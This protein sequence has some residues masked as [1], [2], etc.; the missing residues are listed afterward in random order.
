MIRLTYLISQISF[1]LHFNEKIIFLKLPE[2]ET[3]RYSTAKIEKVTYFM[4]SSFKSSTLYLTVVSRIGILAK[5]IIFS[6]L[7]LRVIN[8]KELKTTLPTPTLSLN[9]T[10]LKL[11]HLTF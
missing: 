11:P 10:L 3:L 1:W 9:E 7:L 6:E 2:F 5:I 4:S 8:L